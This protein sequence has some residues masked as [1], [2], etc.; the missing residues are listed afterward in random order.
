[1]Y[2]G[3]PSLINQI[4]YEIIEF[5]QNPWTILTFYDRTNRFHERQYLCFCCWGVFKVSSCC[6]PTIQKR[7]N[8]NGTKLTKYIALLSVRRI[9][10]A[11]TSLSHS[12]TYTWPEPYLHLG[13]IQRSGTATRPPIASTR[14]IPCRQTIGNV[15]HVKELII[16]NEIK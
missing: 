2:V 15:V 5:L 14:K 8:R 1:M 16:Y 3:K 7:G 13:Y 10:Y 11:S 6:R 12:V 4:F 9:R